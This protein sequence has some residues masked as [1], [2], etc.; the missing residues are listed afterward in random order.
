MTAKYL[1]AA[2]TMTPLR[3]NKQVLLAL[4]VV[5]S[6]FLYAFGVLTLRQDRVPGWIVEAEG[7]IPSAVS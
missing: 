4:M 5:A 7:P 3:V 6:F 2:S 1:A